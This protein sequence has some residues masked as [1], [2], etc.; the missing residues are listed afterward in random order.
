MADTLDIIEELKR[1]ERRGA[2]DHGI[3]DERKNPLS[4]R[5]PKR[6]DLLDTDEFM[7]DLWF[8]LW[9]VL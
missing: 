7:D 6:K 5:R 8:G 3:N 9:K 2:L 1:E 4:E